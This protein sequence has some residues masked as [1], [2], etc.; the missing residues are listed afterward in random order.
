MNHY[1]SNKKNNNIHRRK[2]ATKKEVRFSFSIFHNAYQKESFQLISCIH[3]NSMMKLFFNYF[4][5]LQIICFLIEHSS[6]QQQQQQY[7]LGTHFYINQDNIL[8]DNTL[9]TVS[10]LARP[11]DLVAFIRQSER[12]ARVDHLQTYIDAVDDNT[13]PS[14]NSF[15]DQ[16]QNKIDSTDKCQ[17]YIRDSESLIFQILKYNLYDTLAIPFQLKNL[18][19]DISFN[20]NL[21]TKISTCDRFCRI[22]PSLLTFDHLPSISTR[23]DQQ[24][25]VRFDDEDFNSTT[26]RN[27][28]QQA[29]WATKEL[30]RNQ[31]SWLAYVYLS[32]Y[33]SF[34]SSYH[35]SIDCLRCALTYG[36]NYNDLILIEL[37][38]IVFRYGYIHDAIIFIEKSLDYHLHSKSSNINSL[39]I[40][41]ILH[42]YLGNLC[43]ID[44]RF[45]LAIQFYNRT[46]ILLERIDKFSDNKQLDLFSSSSFGSLTLSSLLNISQQKIDALHCHLSLEFSLQHKHHI[47]QTKLA[48]LNQLRSITDELIHLNALIKRDMSAGQTSLNN[49]R[50]LKTEQKLFI[51]NWKPLSRDRYSS[52]EI[53]SNQRKYSYVMKQNELCS[54]HENY[55][56]FYYHQNHSINHDNYDC[57]PRE[58]I[59]QF[60]PDYYSLQ[61]NFP[62]EQKSTFLSLRL[63]A[64]EQT[65]S[66]Y[67]LDENLSDKTEQITL[68]STT[69]WSTLTSRLPTAVIIQPIEDFILKQSNELYP[70]L[71]THLHLK[72][73]EQQLPTY[74]DCQIHY[75]GLPSIGDYPTIWIPLENKGLLNI[76][77][78]FYQGLNHQN[79]HY[80]L[81]WSPPLCTLNKPINEHL[82]II[83]NHRVL[84]ARSR[85]KAP[86]NRYDTNMLLNLYLYIDSIIDESLQI[87]EFGQRLRSVGEKHE[88]LLPEWI[89]HLLSSLYWRINGHLPH[90]I[91]CGLK[92]HETIIR[93]KT[94][95]QWSDL[96]LINL[97][98]I[99]YLW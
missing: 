1:V 67:L 10:T 80:P 90:A 56:E 58:T 85:S 28:E 97:A 98:N 6:Q 53:C 54:I 48:Q 11:Y 77:Q 13:S 68:T 22:K 59:L 76:K 40:R 45:I 37:A 55:Y 78:A 93:N 49:L 96:T 73:I 33:F 94:Y 38:N 39:Y 2:E 70:P 52:K 87:E 24:E 75:F 15:D 12:L 46:K 44:N 84:S 99:L 17:D 16:Q 69:T 95:K 88:H 26:Y 74:T 79:K 31:T 50:Q 43:T 30:A 14:T 71:K 8:I 91:E 61:T 41:S 63:A 4:T 92:S 42:F 81:P 35:H 9:K 34:N 64:I 18:S 57:Y 82:S 47:L 86:I 29:R 27:Y 32:R 60:S 83:E 51:C 62:F 7:F 36:S 65:Q 72:I 21:A 19:T 66:S 3:S 5:F 23:Y 89:V 20:E 25:F